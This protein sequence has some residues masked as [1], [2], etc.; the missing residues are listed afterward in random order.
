VCLHGV[1]KKTISDRETQFTS[2]FWEKLQESMDTKLNFS[3]AYYPQIDGQTGRVNQILK[4]MLRA[5]ALNDNQSWYKCLL[6][7]EFSYN[8][9]YQ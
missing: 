7:A 1:P 2:K 3:S 4:V 9:I 8:N 5:C 6:Y